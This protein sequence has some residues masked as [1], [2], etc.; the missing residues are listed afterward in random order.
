MGIYGEALGKS[1]NYSGKDGRLHAM[2]LV[3]PLVDGSYTPLSKEQYKA[4][5]EPLALRTLG[6][7]SGGILFPK[8]LLLGSGLNASDWDASPAVSKIHNRMGDCYL[9][10]G[11]VAQ[12]IEQALKVAIDETPSFKITINQLNAQQHKQAER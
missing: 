1:Q 10:E 4:L 5:V 3:V 2:E 6:Q 9:I 12:Y 11:P 7:G 8:E